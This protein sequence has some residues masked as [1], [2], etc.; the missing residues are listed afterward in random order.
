MEQP[1]K[2]HTHNETSRPCFTNTKYARE[3]NKN[4]RHKIYLEVQPH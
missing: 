1:H 3:Q 4:T 2:I